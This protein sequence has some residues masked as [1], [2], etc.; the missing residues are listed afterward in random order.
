MPLQLD[1]IN[2]PKAIAGKPYFVQL[3][4]SGGFPPYTFTVRNLPSG[5]QQIGATIQG[6]P[7]A[8]GTLDIAIEVSDSG[9]LLPN[10]G[11]DA[12]YLHN[13]AQADLIWTVNHNL[14]KYPSV[15]VFTS[16]GDECEGDIRH[17][18]VNQL[19][20]HFSAPF[21]GTCACN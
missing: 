10:K 17:I 3:T 1:T 7:S 13:Q 8:T 14:G 12:S 18:S 2:L 4:A 19:E 11:Y 21:G 20:L 6:T 5:L 16:A 15:T 9:D